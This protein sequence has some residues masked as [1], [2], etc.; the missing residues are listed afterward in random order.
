MRDKL[1]HFAGQLMGMTLFQ[2]GPMPT[3]INQLSYKIILY[4]IKWYHYWAANPSD[5]LYTQKFLEKELINKVSS[6][7]WCRIKREVLIKKFVDL[8]F[9]KFKRQTLFCIDKDQLKPSKPKNF[10]ETCRKS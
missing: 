2:G 10:K 8:L 4:Y 9:L 7:S 6:T 1:F 5:F 3:V